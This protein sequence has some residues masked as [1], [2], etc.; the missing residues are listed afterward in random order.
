MK[1]ES[2][3]RSLKISGGPQ[4]RGSHFRPW[5]N[6]G[7]RIS[8]LD[9]RGDSVLWCDVDGCS[10]Y[11]PIGSFSL[12]AGKNTTGVSWPLTVPLVH[13]EI[14]KFVVKRTAARSER[15]F[16]ISGTN[17]SA[18]EIRIFCSPRTSLTRHLGIKGSHPHVSDKTVKHN[19]TDA[20]VPTF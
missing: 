19:E 20:L 4:S 8:P 6:Q 15:N 1:L 10:S 18:A 11:L 16:T 14:S 12:V 7:M 17:N 9:R 5:V 3:L 2:K 13:V